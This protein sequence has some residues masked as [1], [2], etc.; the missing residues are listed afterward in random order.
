[1]EFLQQ[2]TLETENYWISTFGLS[3]TKRHIV[4]YVVYPHRHAQRKRR[5]AE[6]AVDPSL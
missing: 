6:A 5:K 3:S 1:M 2:V 4:K